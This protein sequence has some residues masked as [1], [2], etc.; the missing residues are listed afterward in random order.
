VRSRGDWFWWKADIGVTG[1]KEVGN[2]SIMLE[3]GLYFAFFIAFSAFMAN[4]LMVGLRARSIN[5][6]GVIYSRVKEPKMFMAVMIMAGWG[7]LFGL[8]MCVVVIAVGLGY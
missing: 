3:T 5:V 8:S 1:S 6:K 2:L 4:R 7:L